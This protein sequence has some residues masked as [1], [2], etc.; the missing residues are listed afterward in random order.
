MTR[1][2]SVAESGVRRTLQRELGSLGEVLPR[3]QRGAG[4]CRA[5]GWYA[6]LDGELVF[7]GDHLAVALVTIAELKGARDG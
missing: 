3:I 1:V 6:K 7:L 5:Q 4:A 2:K